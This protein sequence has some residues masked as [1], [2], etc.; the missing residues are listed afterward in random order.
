MQDFSLHALQQ[1]FFE[2]LFDRE[3]NINTLQLN[4]SIPGSIEKR[5]DIYRNNVFYSLGV[6]MADLYPVIK[7]LVGTD[8]FKAL[9]RAYLQTHPP[10]KAAMVYFGESFPDFLTSFEPTKALVWLSDVARLELAWHQSYHSSD[11]VPLRPES[12]ANV[13]PE[14]LASSEIVLHPTLRLLK[15][16]YP[17]LQIWESNQTEEENSEIIDLDSGGEAVCIFRPEFEVIVK[18]LD[19]GTYTFLTTLRD[20]S[21]LEQAMIMATE[22][23]EGFAS[24][25]C[26]A[27]CLTD[28][29]FEKIREEII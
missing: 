21:T 27:L 20:G 15:S 16:P 28:G 18:L 6:A 10:T 9:S 3:K 23:D 2:C 1:H 19:T 29:L 17:I 7:R 25:L 26:L 11:A 8:F 14:Q 13:I 4:E 24:D 5:L 22:L 12:L